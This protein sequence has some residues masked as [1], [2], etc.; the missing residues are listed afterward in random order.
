MRKNYPIYDVETTLRPDQYLISRTDLKGRITYA[1][2]AFIDISGFS[3]DELIGKAHNIV[4]HPDVPPALYQDLWDTLH[5]GKTWSG[6]VKNRRKDGGY[7]WVLAS[8]TP[9]MSGDTVT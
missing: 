9:I 1:N 3:R 6:V 2:P 5:A 7:Y 4:R 8:V